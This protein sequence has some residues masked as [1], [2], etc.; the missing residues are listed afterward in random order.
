MNNMKT[1][2]F[3]IVVMLMSIALVSCGQTR[4]EKTEVII[5]KLKFPEAQ[6]MSYKFKL[7]GLKTQA[8]GKDSIAVVELEKKLSEKEIVKRISSAFNE[9]FSD[10][11]I[12]EIHKFVQSGAYEKMFG[13]GGFYKIVS[14]KFKDIDSEI[15][16]ITK[17]FGERMEK[18][19]KRFQP[20]PVDRV[21]GFYETVDYSRSAEIENIKLKDNPALT[22]KDI[23]E[24]KKV[25]SDHDNSPEISIVFTKEGARKFYL[26]TKENIGK[27]IV[28]VVARQIVSCP[29]VNMGILGGKAMIA[30]DFSEEEIDK[31]V[32]Q[33]KR[34]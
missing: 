20:I 19:I 2:F 5:T 31:M 15:E 1:R 33:L 11:E 18:P 21:D 17:G 8:T 16:E 10:S 3:T 25:Y 29:I 30:G 32:E 9:V 12:D 24:V 28:I 4:Q 14:S 7:D 26:L 27:P 22:S 13:S 34:K 6:K 23:Q